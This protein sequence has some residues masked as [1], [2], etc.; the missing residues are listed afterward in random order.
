MDRLHH[1]IQLCK[2]HGSDAAAEPNDGTMSS[3]LYLAVCE[4]RNDEAVA[5]L[6]ANQVADQV[7]AERNNVLHLAAEQGHAELIQELYD[8][9]GDK[10]L[11]SSQN[12]VLDTPLNCAARA[13]HDTAVSV[14][15]RLA[16]KSGDESILRRKNEAGDTALHLAAR[17]GHAKAVEVMVNAVPELASEV[18][19]AGL[20]PLYLAVVSRSEPAVRAITTSCSHASAAGPSSQNALHA[21]VFQ[22]KRMVGLLLDWEPSLAGEPDDSGSTPLHFASSDGDHPVVAAILRAAPYTVHKRD[23]DGL[24]ALH[25]A[26]GMG[27]A[28]VAKALIE[29][30][31]DAA[32]LRDHRGGTFLHAAARGG[33]SKVVSLAIATK[34]PTLRRLLNTQDRDGNT[35]LHLVVAAGAPDV[36]EAL[37]RDGEV[38]A[39]VMNNDGHTPLDLAARSTSLFSMLGL[40]VTLAAFGGQSRP[41]RRDRVKR[42]SGHDIGKGIEK[43]SDS[44]AVV[45]VLIAT[46]AFTAAYSLPGSYEQ[47]DDPGK[48][49]VKG[50]AVLQQ[51]TVFKCFLVLDS[52]ALM[53]SVVAVVL[54]VFGKASSSD[55]SWKSFMVALHTTGI[56]LYTDGFM[57][58][59]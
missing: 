57:P 39:D 20:S 7:S 44:L 51:K 22:G 9:L 12:S 13:G 28:G 26:A 37:M 5:L 10:S 48:M 59:A 27:H 33:H 6:A 58:S 56:I 42:W 50:R 25:V 11:L 38:R 21:A 3:K 14:L 41:Q 29:A 45:A 54:L 36:V 34:K 4:G 8:R 46:V 23:S 40:V 43:T 53:A 24:S 1:C 31:Q 55:G 16:R 30:C 47:N 35:P 52:F 49:V 19:D 17:L 18:N 32:E 2:G 15:V